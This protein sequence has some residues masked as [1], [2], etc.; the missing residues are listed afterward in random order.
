[1]PM[2]IVFQHRQKYVLRN[3]MTSLKSVPERLG[4]A[5]G[6]HFP[7]GPGGL[8]ARDELRHLA[9]RLGQLAAVVLQRRG[10]L[11]RHREQVDHR[12]S[13]MRAWNSRTEK[14]KLQVMK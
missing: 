10:L 12:F 1:M 3:F 2:P 8:G 9:D 11:L 7:D 6:Q 5:G 4:G 14:M 13:W